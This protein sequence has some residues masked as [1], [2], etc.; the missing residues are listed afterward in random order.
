MILVCA[1]YVIA[2]TPG[3][4]YFLLLHFKFDYYTVTAHCVT[5]F[6]GFFY[7]CANPFI[8]ALKFIPVR[9]ILVGLIP[10]KKSEQ[11]D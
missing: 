2:W 4:T 5:M 11:A 6:L 3:Y 1:F 9:C 10:W 7:I 8:Y